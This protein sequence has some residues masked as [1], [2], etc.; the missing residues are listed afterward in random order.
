M[1]SYSFYKSLYDRELNRR[2]DLDTAISLPITVIT[3]IVV[4]NSYTL[5][6][7]VVQSPLQL[8]LA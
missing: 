3:V 1:D 7:L 8:E 2:K 5:K 6:N 4:A